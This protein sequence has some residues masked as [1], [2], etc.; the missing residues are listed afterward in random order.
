M[1]IQHYIVAFEVEDSNAEEERQR[2][3]PKH[4]EVFWLLGVVSSILHRIIYNN[5]HYK[6]NIDKKCGENEHLRDKSKL[7]FEAAE[8]YERNYIDFNQQTGINTIILNKM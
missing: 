2:W 5:E 4:I 8:K 1:Q 3:W 7:M 6:T